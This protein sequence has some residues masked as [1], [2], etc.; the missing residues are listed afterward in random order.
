MASTYSYLD[1]KKQVEPSHVKSHIKLA[2]THPENHW[3]RAYII[4]REYPIS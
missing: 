4:R 2:C 3:G 1:A